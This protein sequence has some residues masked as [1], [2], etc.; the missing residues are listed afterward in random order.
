MLC[1]GD[2]K[3]ASLAL[4]EAATISERAATSAAT[5]PAR[6][7]RR[8]DGMPATL[9][10]D[11]LQCKLSKTG[12]PMRSVGK[13]GKVRLVYRRNGERMSRKHGAVLAVA[14]AGLRGAA[15]W[16]GSSDTSG[17]GG[18]SSSSS[19]SGGKGSVKLALV[20]YS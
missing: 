19:S 8:R 4:A 3:S 16:G 18:S 1:D 6:A 11:C 13:A 2:W 20:A 10:G 9:P 12:I 5:A 14:I 7:G 15:G 17:G